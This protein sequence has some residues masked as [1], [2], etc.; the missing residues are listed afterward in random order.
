[1][2]RR[3]FVQ[4]VAVSA[5]WPLAAGAQQPDR[6]RRVGIVMPYAKGDTES[7]AWIQ[8]FKQE[9]ANLGWVDGRNIQFDERWNH[10]QHG[11]GAVSS[12]RSDGV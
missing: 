12:C 5:A 7:E 4:G 10:R 8:A 9:L 2:R 3:D 1:M 11:Y 6:V